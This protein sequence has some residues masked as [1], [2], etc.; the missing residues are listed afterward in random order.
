MFC[1]V[2][3][4]NWNEDDVQEWMESIGL[5]EFAVRT[6][7]FIQ[8][9]FIDLFVKT[10]LYKAHIN[11]Q[12]LLMLTK[13]DLSVCPFPLFCSIPFSSSPS[14]LVLMYVK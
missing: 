4:F 6:V 5:S 9:L 10:N 11:G 7:Y 3:E 12:S 8:L 13:S 2:N 1:A 14:P